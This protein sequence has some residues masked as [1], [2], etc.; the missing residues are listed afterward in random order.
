M[1]LDDLVAS[2]ARRRHKPEAA[3]LMDKLPLLSLARV[4]DSAAQGATTPTDRKW[5]A[6]CAVAPGLENTE[7]QHQHEGGERDDRWRQV[8]MRMRRLMRG[9]GGGSGGDGDKRV[10]GPVTMLHRDFWLEALDDQHRYGCYL[11][12]FH[13]AWKL[14]A[15]GQDAADDG[16]NAS[17]F[18]WLDHGD[19]RA[20]DLPECSH[21]ELRLSRVVYCSHK[22][23][24][25]YELRFVAPSEARHVSNARRNGASAHAQTASARG[26]VAEYAES[27]ALAH[28]DERS[29]WIFVVDLGGRMYLGR[30]RKGRFH[31][32]SFVAGAPVVAAGKIVIKLGRVLAIEPHSGHFKPK[33][34]SLSALRGLL[35]RQGVDVD[36]VTFV[37]PKKWA[38]EW[39]FP[40]LEESVDL[41][42][43]ASDTDDSGSN[44][45]FGHPDAV[46]GDD[47][48]DAGDEDER[49][50][51]AS[52]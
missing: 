32:S 18:C 48:N 1:M 28:T 8:R 37:K 7:E 16:V 51:P 52:P 42:D 25:R 45:F 39:P 2:I 6:N 34:A 3:E 13:K 36:A 27:H 50:P 12:A 23:R 33:L 40:E 10:G 29:K 41:D 35:E 49:W 30:K 14:A 21:D 43:F 46:E 17:F 5:P 38:G 19:G 44:A 26:S 15:S 24:R 11:R 31:H 4:P 20:L 22:E 47:D 9:D